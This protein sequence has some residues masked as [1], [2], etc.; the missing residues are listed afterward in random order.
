MNWYKY[1]NFTEDEFKCSHTGVC[2]MDKQFMDKL[3]ALRTEAGFPF[4]ITSG[5]RDPSHPVEAKKNKPGEHTLG[6]AADIGIS[7]QNADKLVELSFKHGFTRRGINQKGSS[8][9]IHLG[10][11]TPEDGF[12]QTI[13]S[14]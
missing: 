3:Q 13:W 7:G 12:P 2:K 5:Y 1:P 4:I 10:T 9:F 8:R 11:A 14:Y 6:K